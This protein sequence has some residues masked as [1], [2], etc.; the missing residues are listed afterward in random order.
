LTTPP[1]YPVIYRAG[2]GSAVDQ[3]KS[4]LGMATNERGAIAHASRVLGY[5]RAPFERF[6]ATLAPVLDWDNDGEQVTLA[7]YV[8]KQLITR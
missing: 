3:I 5:S 8:G 7:W 4:P 6:T 2:I 1:R